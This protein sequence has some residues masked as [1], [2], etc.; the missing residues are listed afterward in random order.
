M[1]TI[2]H[3]PV[4]SRG[5]QQALT[6]ICMCMLYVFA[7]LMRANSAE[8]VLKAY[9]SGI[10]SH[11]GGSIACLIIIVQELKMQFSPMHVSN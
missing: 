9:L 8:N 7:I 10:F 5:H 1:D 4:T 3:L 11:K 2:S 6:E